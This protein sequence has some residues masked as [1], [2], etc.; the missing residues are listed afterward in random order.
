[1]FDQLETNDGVVCRLDVTDLLPTHVRGEG[2]EGVYA[3]RVEDF[4]YATPV[5][6]LS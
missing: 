2:K 1:V 6:S 3:V 5:V 4:V